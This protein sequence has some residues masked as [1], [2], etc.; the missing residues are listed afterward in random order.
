MGSTLTCFLGTLVSY[1]HC[2]SGGKDPFVKKAPP[3][4]V[5]TQF[6][7]SHCHRFIGMT[8]GRDHRLMQHYFYRSFFNVPTRPALFGLGINSHESIL[9]RLENLG[10]TTLFGSDAVL[11]LATSNDKIPDCE[12]ITPAQVKALPRMMHECKCTM[13]DDGTEA[14]AKQKFTVLGS[15]ICDARPYQVSWYG[16]SWMLYIFC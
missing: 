10:L 13:M 12:G 15:P 3:N 7:T 6:S 14:C 5:L 2:T 16:I 9:Q 4:E 1:R 11:K 8:D